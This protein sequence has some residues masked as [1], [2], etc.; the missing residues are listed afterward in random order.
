MEIFNPKIPLL[1]QN[2]PFKQITVNNKIVN[3]PECWY[4]WY[5]KSN[6]DFRSMDFTDL[7]F[8]CRIRS[9][10]DKARS[11]KI[12]IN[13]LIEWNTKFSVII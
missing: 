1:Q 7:K 4:E 13:R 8:C 6:E 3:I 9:I 11:K 10:S 2:G 5:F 12:L